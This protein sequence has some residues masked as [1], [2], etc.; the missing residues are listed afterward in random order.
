M[1]GPGNS[2]IDPMLV[3]G[4]ANWWLDPMFVR[5]A[6]S[7][8]SIAASGSSRSRLTETRTNDGVRRETGVEEGVRDPADNGLLKAEEELMGLI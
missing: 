2:C 8:A 1:A 4:P 3:A 5:F 7:D 6:R